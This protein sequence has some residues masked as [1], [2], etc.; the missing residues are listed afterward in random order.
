ME[1]SSPVVNGLHG[2]STS[3]H[4][5]G[6]DHGLLPQQ[7]SNG[8]HGSGDVTLSQ[9]ISRNQVAIAGRKR[10]REDTEECDFKRMRKSGG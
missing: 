10:C 9:G 8:F 7:Q 4:G 1:E 6:G 3:V 2:L 5:G